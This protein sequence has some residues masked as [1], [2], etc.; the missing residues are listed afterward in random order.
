MELGVYFEDLSPYSY[1]LK[2]P[3][4]T[5]LNVGWLDGSHPFEV[6]PLNEPAFRKLADI[7]G[8][9]PPV[10][11][12]VNKMRSFARCPICR[13]DQFPTLDP[14]YRMQIGMTEIWIPNSTRGYFAAPSLIVHYV[15]EH[16]YSPP[17]AFW[18]AVA[19]FDLTQPYDAQAIYLQS[20]AG[21]F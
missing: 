3:L 21:H 7:C 18:D 1:Y 14:G 10:Y 12:H 15:A 17:Q 5:V 16:G 4:E 6:G 11:A 13:L 19:A 9:K 20:I 8:S 2:K